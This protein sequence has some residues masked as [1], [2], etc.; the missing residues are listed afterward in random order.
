[1]VKNP[2]CKAGDVGCIPGRG[3]EILHARE[4]LSLYATTKRFVCC[5]EINQINKY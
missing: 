1:M 2:P 3:T 4:Q 5:K